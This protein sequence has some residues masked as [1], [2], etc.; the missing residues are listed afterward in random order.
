MNETDDDSAG[1]GRL[2]VDGVTRLL[3]LEKTRRILDAFTAETPELSIPQIIT[4]TGLPT[5]TG[6]RIVRNMVF[7][8]ILE[9][10]GDRYRIGLAIVR[11]ASLAIMGRDLVELSRA[12]LNRLRDETGESALLSVREGSQAV[13]IAVSNSR[14]SVVR[15]LWI[16]EVRPLDAGSTG[17]AFLAFDPEALDALDAIGTGES[18]PVIARSGPDRERL[19]GELANI[20]HVGF[21]ASFEER[22]V[23]AAGITAPILDEAGALAA[24]IG[25]TGPSTRLTRDTVAKYSVSVLEAANTIAAKLGK[26][27]STT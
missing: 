18:G 23:G 4:K 21:A 26:K 27:S 9:R 22:N 19:M 8:G 1:E 17:K 24:C 11:W 10:N 25:L 5:S 7:D 20:R 16:G 3:V 12:P 6:V 2:Q 15:Q 13:V 14:H